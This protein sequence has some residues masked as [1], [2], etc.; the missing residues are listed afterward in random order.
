MRGDTV[1]LGCI[2]R[3]IDID[4]GIRCHDICSRYR[5]YRDRLDESKKAIHID[6]M[7][8]AYKSAKINRVKV[9]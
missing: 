5:I 6:K 3:W 8:Q 7:Y 2:N 1:C 9:R 4:K